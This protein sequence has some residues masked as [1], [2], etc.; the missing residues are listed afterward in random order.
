MD[1]TQLHTQLPPIPTKRLT[2]SMPAYVYDRLQQ[3]PKG[4]ISQFVTE[5]V[6][7]RFTYPEILKEELR[8][9]QKAN[10]PFD[11]LRQLMRDAPLPNMPWPEMKKLMRKG[12][13]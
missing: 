12:L 13:M 4:T 11:Q 3:L 2:I 8:G 6:Q 5:S 9:K 1:N 10:E 7:S